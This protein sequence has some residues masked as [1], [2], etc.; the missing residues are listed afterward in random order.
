[1]RTREMTQ[2]ATPNPERARTNQSE[3]DRL[4]DL[5]LPG[6]AC[7]LQIVANIMKKHENL[8]KID[9]PAALPPANRRQY[10]EKA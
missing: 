3:P 10:H 5:L 8:M 6:S 4:T 2:R 9:P 1:M 7:P